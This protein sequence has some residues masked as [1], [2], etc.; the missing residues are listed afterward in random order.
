MSARPE[1]FDIDVPEKESLV[2]GRIELDDL[3]WLNVV[4][5]L[6]EK[7]L[8]GRGIRE[9]TEKFTPSLSTVAPNGWGR[10]GSVENEAWEVVCRISLFPSGT[11]SVAGMAKSPDPHRWVRAFPRSDR[12]HRL[13]CPK[14]GSVAG[15][16]LPI[17][18][19]AM[20]MKFRAL[21]ARGHA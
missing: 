6:K 1:A 17:L 13:P 15:T 2:V 11:P 10:P 7:Q 9:K 16:G 19:E 20:T 12:K 5:P 3:D 4:L 14:R 18:A 8:D 21:P